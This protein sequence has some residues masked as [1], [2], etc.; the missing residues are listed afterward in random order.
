MK[1]IMISTFVNTIKMP[2]YFD[3]SFNSIYRSTL[4]LLVFLYISATCNDGVLNQNEETTDCGG[5]CPACTCEDGILNQD[6]EKTDYGG[7]CPACPTCEDGV[8]NQDEEKTD[9]GGSCPACP[10]C[11][12]GIRNQNEQETDCGGSCQA[13]PSTSYLTFTCKAKSCIL[14]VII[15]Q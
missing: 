1:Y 2:K 4:R 12:D 7:S 8:L 11:D 5:I 14:F 3:I 13:C 10:T 9:C 15:C 6:E